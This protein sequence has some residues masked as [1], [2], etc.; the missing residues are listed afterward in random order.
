MTPDA[1]EYLRDCL[2][3][4]PAE[5]RPMLVLTTSQTDG[6]NPPRW[7][8]DGESFVI[9][10][11]EAYEKSEIEFTESKLW[12]RY[13]AIET[14]ALKR[15]S[16]KFLDLREVPS[17]R[18]I[19]NIKKFVLVAAAGPKPAG[20]VSGA[21][22]S[23]EEM[24][25][26]LSVGVL[27]VLGGFMGMGVIWICS[28]F[29]IMSRNPPKWLLSNWLLFFAAGWIAGAI[30]SFNIFKSVFKTSGRTKLAQKELQQ[31][32]FGWGGADFELSWFL[33]IGIPL[34]LTASLILAVGRFTRTVE[35][36]TG[37]VFVAIVVV[38]GAVMYICDRLPRRLNFWL[39]ILG[40][41][42]TFVLGFW[43]FKTYGP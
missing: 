22:W 20:Q 18:G 7:Q 31:K 27:T 8:Y 2:R 11:F 43:Y 19:F 14:N 3:E 16:G 40:W 32:Y 28:G 34:P 1:E 33:F 26:R 29:V 30:V 41:V 10:D 9:D 23:P 37:L 13:V 24:K 12:G 38:F 17:S 15:L 42:L 35:E 6:Q 5:V 21:N 36:K 25:R 39:G 4:F